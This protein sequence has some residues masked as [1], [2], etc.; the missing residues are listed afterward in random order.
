M[1]KWRYQPIT[2]QYSHTLTN[3][4]FGDI[5]AL[6]SLRPLSAGT[7]VLVNYEYAFD[8]APPWYQQL[9]ISNILE[10]YTKTRY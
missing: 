2:A 1:E 7:E 8:S 10:A 9:N 3:P 5:P 6:R 4:R